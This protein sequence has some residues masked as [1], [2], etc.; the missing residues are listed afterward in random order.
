MKQPVHPS[1]KIK[2]TSKI[3]RGEMSDSDDY[4]SH[5]EESYEEADHQQE[6][7]VI[8]L[9]VVA[10]LHLSSLSLISHRRPT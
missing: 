7:Q 3:E 9:L 8:L 1:S 4:D 2:L 10:L 6:E 5:E